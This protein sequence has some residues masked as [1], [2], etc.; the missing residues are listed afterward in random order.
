MWRDDHAAIRS[1]EDARELAEYRAIRRAEQVTEY[2]D[3]D[4]DCT[5]DD[6][7]G[8]SRNCPMHGE[9]AI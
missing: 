3:C 7:W 2:L 8:I 4:D 6:E 5:C 9:E 1:V